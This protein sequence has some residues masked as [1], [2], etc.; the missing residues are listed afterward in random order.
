MGVGLGLVQPELSHVICFALSSIIFLM[1]QKIFKLNWRFRPKI[2]FFL[3]QRIFFRGV[4]ASIERNDCFDFVKFCT[5]PYFIVHPNIP[6]Y[7]FT[8]CSGEKGN[9]T[10][11]HHPCHQR[12]CCCLFT[13]CSRIGGSYIDTSAGVNKIPRIKSCIH[14]KV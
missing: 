13:S 9:K 8:L 5:F 1:Q 14:W 12:K 2:I 3:A 10:F 4:V 7:P 6:R 11:G